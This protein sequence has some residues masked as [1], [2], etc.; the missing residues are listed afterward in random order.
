VCQQDKIFKASLPFNGIAEV[1]TPRN[2]EII[3]H[4]NVG[5]VKI[6]MNQAFWK[7]VSDAAVN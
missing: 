3:V 1:N 6:A 2:K 7:S 4:K 5:I